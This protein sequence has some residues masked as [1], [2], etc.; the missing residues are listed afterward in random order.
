[1]SFVRC[2][3]PAILLGICIQPASAQSKP[4][5][6]ETKATQWPAELRVIPLK[7]ADCQQVVQQLRELLPPD[8]RGRMRFVAD[9]NSN[10]LLASGTAEQ[11]ATVARFVGM[12]DQE[13]NPPAPKQNTF[14]VLSLGAVDPDDSFARGL[15]AVVPSGR[16]AVDRNRKVVVIS[17]DEHEVEAVKSFVA[18]Y[19]KIASA[20]RPPRA[21]R[22]RIVWLASGMLDSEQVPP[23]A[24][25]K[26]VSDE[27]AGIGIEGLHL[28]SQSIL[29][30]TAGSEFQMQSE[31]RVDANVLTVSGVLQESQGPANVLSLSLAVKR[32]KAGPL[33]ELSSRI[34]LPTAQYVVVGTTPTNKA[35]SVFVV[36]VLHGDEKP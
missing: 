8:L 33:C 11:L 35:T 28:I 21:A 26:K 29:S 17:G 31:T 4:N 1:M 34:T 13:R 27:L 9:P 25:L 7:F 6:P 19:E 32:P 14:T 23:P 2:V 16:F 10:A 15:N 5:A 18:S 24:D 20:K 22:L 30:V 3:V 36:Q 12:I